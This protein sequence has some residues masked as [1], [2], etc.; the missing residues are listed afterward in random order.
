MN[1]KKNK[2]DCQLKAMGTDKANEKVVE[3]LSVPDPDP[4]VGKQVLDE[5][6]EKES[7]DD[8]ESENSG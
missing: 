1:R 3:D 5:L 2:I 4:E 6:M 7:K 8:R